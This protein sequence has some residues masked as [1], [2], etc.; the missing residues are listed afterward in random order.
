MNAPTKAHTPTKIGYHEYSD[1]QIS[2]CADCGK[3]I[4]KAYYPA[5]F[6]ER[7]AEYA[8]NWADKT[9]VPGK[10]ADVWIYRFNYEC[11]KEVA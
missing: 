6:G 2:V 3:D 8:R 5:E 10:S 4:S 11:G 1:D 9:R 7:N